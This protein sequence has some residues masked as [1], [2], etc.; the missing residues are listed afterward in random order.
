MNNENSYANICAQVNSAFEVRQLMEYIGW[1]ADKIVRTGDVYFAHCPIHRDPVFRTLVLN[2]RN[3]TYHCKHVNC[4]GNRPSDF[5]DLLTR[6]THKSLP[7]V[8]QESVNHFGADYFR[9]T[10]KQLAVIEDLVRQVQAGCEAE[11]APPQ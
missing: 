6:V 8:I 2:P 3:N 5:L 9:L 11:Q 1:N 4:S 10:P 7:E